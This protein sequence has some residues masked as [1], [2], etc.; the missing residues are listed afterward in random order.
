MSAKDSAQSA[1]AAAA[2]VR[3]NPYVN[4]VIHD[5]ELRDNA[6]VAYH[7]AVRAFQRIQSA[8]NPAGALLDDKKLHHELQ[9]AQ[10]NLQAAVTA[11]REGPIKRRRKHR[12]RN[13]ILL[14]V[15][16][17]GVALVVSEGLRNK[18][19]DLLFGAEEEFDYTSTTVATPAPAPVAPAPSAVVNGGTPS[20]APAE[21]ETAESDADA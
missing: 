8:K 5:A 18:V 17:A 19:L 16:T 21:A 7:H 13:V 10:H 11:L 1:L 20:A 2:M 12:L 4:R 3:E 9:T 6:R 15:A 14:T